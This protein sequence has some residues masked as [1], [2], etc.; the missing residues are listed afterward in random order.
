MGV[1]YLAI[2][3]FFILGITIDN[4][5]FAE[6]PLGVIS[7]RVKFHG[8]ILAP[9]THKNSI[10]SLVCGKEI[11]IRPIRVDE[12]TLGLQFVVVTIQT[13]P[14]ASLLT[15]PR[16][17]IVRNTE[18]QFWQ[19]VTA[20]RLGDDVEVQNQDPILHNTHITFG[21]RTILNVAQL[22]NSR[23]IQKPLSLKG[24]YKIR[25]DKHKFMAGALWV[26]DHPYFAVTDAAG[27]FELPPLNA[28]TYVIE[29]WHEILG[30]LTQEV[31]V[32]M[33]GKV[34]VELVYR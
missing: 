21:R 11:E 27:N 8:E 15:P 5:V 20:A 26:Y 14:S 30:V 34:A 32:P 29:A 6:E 7:G 18:C 17:V 28:G 1:F 16:D 25:C 12:K 24:L 9:E 3:G 23:P 13:S 10:D 2:F 4:K 33:N 22:P 19:P 31:T